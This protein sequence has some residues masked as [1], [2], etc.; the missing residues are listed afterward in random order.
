[1][2]AAQFTTT[3]P[4]SS[5]RSIALT[6]ETILH[7]EACLTFRY[8]MQSNLV[9]QAT[10][11]SMTRVLLHFRVD[12]G[13]SFHKTYVDLQLGRYQLLWDV[14]YDMDVVTDSEEEHDMYR[15]TIDDI[16]IHDITCAELSKLYYQSI[17]AA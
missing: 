15:A 14:T 2:L 13:L 12:G 4:Y 8:S 7:N 11:V 5:A 1:M 6:P 17:L 10:N 9:V 3:Q 16:V